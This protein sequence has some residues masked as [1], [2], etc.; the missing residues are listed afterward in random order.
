MKKGITLT[1]TAIIMTLLLSAS[2]VSINIDLNDDIIKNNFHME[3]DSAGTPYFEKTITAGSRLDIVNVELIPVS[4][5]EYTGSFVSMPNPDMSLDGQVHFE[6]TPDCLWETASTGFSGNNTIITL[7]I[8]PYDK[9]NGIVYTSFNAMFTFEEKEPVSIKSSFDNIYTKNADY[10]IPVY[11]KEGASIDQYASLDM[12]IITEAAFESR[13]NDYIMQSRLLGMRTCLFT[14]EY[15]YSNY[16]GAD[17]AEQIRNFIKDV[18]NTK[19]IRYVLLGGDVDIVPVRYIYNDNYFYYGYVPTDMYYADMDGDWNADRDNVIGEVSQDLIDAYPDLVVSRLPFNCAEELDVLLGKFFGYIYENNA[20]N[21]DKWLLAGASLSEGLSDGTGQ[22][23][24]DRL[25]TYPNT[26]SYN[27]TKLYSPNIDTFNYISY[28]SGDEQLNI[29]SFASRLTSGYHYIN[30][31]DHSN[32]Y[33]LGTGNLETYSE[34]YVSDSSRINNDSGTYSIMFSMGCSPNGFDRESVSEMLMN[35]SRSSVTSFMGFTRTG[36]TSSQYMM[37]EYWQV[38]LDNSTMFAGDAFF[39]AMDDPRMYFRLA[40]NMLGFCNMPVYKKTADSLTLILPDSIDGT[41]FTVSVLCGLYAESNATVVIYDGTDI[42]VTKTDAK[43]E[44]HFEQTL[45]DTSV[46]VCASA[47]SCIPVIDTV[48]VSCLLNISVQNLSQDILNPEMFNFT[49]VSNA[50]GTFNNVRLDFAAADSNITISDYTIISSISR[51]DT[52]RGSFYTSSYKAPLQKTSVNVGFFIDVSGLEFSDSIPTVIY[53]DSFSIIDFNIC[54][55]AYNADFID[56]VKIINRSSFSSSAQISIRATSLDAQV[57]P[58]EFSINYTKGDTILLTNIGLTNVSGNVDL[59]LSPFTV[60]IETNSREYN[61]LVTAQPIKDSVS[62]NC[63]LL[64]GGIHLTHNSAFSTGMLYR[65]QNNE[66]FVYL[67]DFSENTGLF[68]DNTYSS[69][70]VRYYAVFFDNMDRPACTTAVS[71]INA[72]VSTSVSDVKLGASYYGK[73]N[74][75]KYYA[76]SSFNSADLN[77]DGYDEFVVLSD[78]GRIFI[79]DKDLND[80][81]PFT[82]TMAKYIE[83]SPCIG[84]IDMNGKYDIIIPNGGGSDTTMFIVMNPFS[85]PEIKAV[86]GFGTL[87]ASPVIADIN[88]SPGNELLIGSSKGFYVLS[89]NAAVLTSYTKNY[90]NIVG[91][92]VAKDQG[93]MAI[94]DY[95]GKLVMMDFTGKISSG[96]PFYCNEVTKAPVIITDLENDG[97]IEIMLGTTSGKLHAINENGTEKSGFPFIASAPIYQSP[98]IADFDNDNVYE[99]VIMDLSGNVYIISNLGTCN[100]QYSTGDAN[101]TFNEPIIA[102]VDLDSKQE[103]VVISYSGNMHILNSLCQREADVFSLNTNITCTPLASELSAGSAPV[104]ITKDLYGNI[105]KISFLSQNKSPSG[106][107]FPKTLYD[108]ANTAYIRNFTTLKDESAT[109]IKNS[110][111]DYF[112]IDS[113]LILSTLRMSYSFSSTAPVTYTLYNKVGMSVYNGKIDTDKSSHSVDMKTLGLSSGEY[114]LMV[115]ADKPYKEKILLLK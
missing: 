17:N 33:W 34:M 82:L 76:K 32:E 42:Y 31:I 24:N 9:K 69:S 16:S 27:H 115:K 90:P 67:G 21:L 40:V 23:F 61:T 43:G 89:M 113:N 84:D 51:G 37:E 48:K 97:N 63:S 93:L 49:I 104:I 15:I 45:S 30:H 7:K 39:S 13:F 74:G 108:K 20:Q 22:R 103:I 8:Y 114:F 66:Q 1:I 87:T 11:S 2:T 77:N 50:E 79:L 73:L 29:N 54:G 107:E 38:L 94:L 5:I 72:F 83:T 88:A 47:V 81:T 100:A 25:V 109:L 3:N 52:I 106:L 60:S 92:S 91:I 6:N 35:S 19:G 98:V 71:T 111:Q 110:M 53:P 46:I 36:W 112:S 75:L 86:T 14:T 101:N 41:G 99:T 12:I 56:T 57:K 10:I 70:N 85:K 102:D 65:S 62:L 26:Y 96:F 44:A 80:I 18:Y 64:T 68:I 4:Q 95:Y 59:T 78:D 28:W 55:D 105:M 58:N